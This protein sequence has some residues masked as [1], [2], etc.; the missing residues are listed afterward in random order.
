MV[1]ETSILAEGGGWDLKTMAMV[2]LSLNS[3]AALVQ[4]FLTQ[5]ERIIGNICN[6]ILQE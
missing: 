3:A 4:F 1:R 5:G 2:G 6:N